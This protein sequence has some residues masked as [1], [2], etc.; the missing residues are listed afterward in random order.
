MNATRITDS[1]IAEAAVSSL[2]TRPTSPTAFGGKGYTSA[3]MKAAFDRLPLLLAKRY[4]SLLEDV[5][6]LGE[7]SL[8]ESIPTGISE[9]HTLT[10]LFSDVK[11]GNLASYLR[12]GGESLHSIIA[13]LLL[14]VFG[15]DINE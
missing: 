10:D 11:N 7:G 9:G 6:S 2:P 1:E 4:N 13:R 3:E 5:E 14:A 8:A 15:E 12:V